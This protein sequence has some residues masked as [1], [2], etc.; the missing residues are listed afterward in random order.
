MEQPTS[1]AFAAPPDVQAIYFNEFASF[2]ALQGAGLQAN[3]NATDSVIDENAGGMI[4]GANDGAN[5]GWANVH[6][7]LFDGSAYV[8]N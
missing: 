3:T 5:G 7:P 8:V 2:T 6:F 1:S 4:L